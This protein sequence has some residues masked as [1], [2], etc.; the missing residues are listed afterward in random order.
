MCVGVLALFCAVSV[1]ESDLVLA[2]KDSTSAS[3]VVIPAKAE[4]VQEWAAEE[5]V[6]YVERV[7]GARLE[8]QRDDKPLPERAVLIGE[9]RYSKELLG[10]GFDFASLGDE[11]FRVA[12]QGRHLLIA[13]NSP[14]GVLYG[15]Y[16]VLERFGDVGFFAPWRIVSREKGSFA[17]PKGTDY[18]EKP[19]FRMREPTWYVFRDPDFASMLRVNGDYVPFEGRNGGRAHWFGGGLWNC[20]TFH[21][22][23]PPEKYFAEHPEYFSLVK[24]KRD[25]CAELCLTH[26]DVLRIA[27]SNVLARIRRDPGA[28]YYGVSQ[29]D[30]Q[31]PCTCENCLKVRAEEGDAD[32]GALVRFVN[33]IAEKVE[34]E[35]PDKI[36]QT[37][38]YQYNRKPPLK[39]R[40]RHNTTVCL[41]TIEC[42][43]FKPIPESDWKWDMRLRDDIRGWSAMTERLAIWDYTVNFTHYPMP[44]PNLNALQGNIRF[45]RENKV[46]EIYEQGAYQGRGGDMAELRAYM[47]AKWLWNPDLDQEALIG[48]FLEGYYG[49]AAPF[50]RQYLKELH[51]LPYDPKTRPLG[52]FDEPNLQKTITRAFIDRARGLWR[53]AEAAVSEDAGLLDNVKMS[54]FG[55]VYMQY[56][57][58]E[59]SETERKLELARWLLARVKEHPEIRLSEHRHNHERKL[60]EYRNCVEA[61]E[62]PLADLSA[63]DPR[64]VVVAAGTKTAYQGHPTMVQLDYGRL[65]AVWTDG[66]GGTCG[67]AAESADGGKTWMRIDERFPAGW[68]N[69]VNC[70]SIYELQGPDGKKRLWIWAQAKLP[71][72]AD[73]CDHGIRFRYPE[74]AMPSVMSED[75][76]KTWREMP[77]L[78]PKFKCVMAFSSIIR[79]KDG[80]YLGAFH[81]GPDGKD[82]HPLGVWTSVTKDGGFTWSEPKRALFERHNSFCEPSLIRSPDGKTLAMLCR[83]NHR[84]LGR[85]VIAFSTDEGRHWSDYRPTSWGLTGDRHVAVH[86][87][88]GRYFIAMRD[89]AVGSKTWG[90]YVAWV[91]TWGDLA[92]SGSGAIRLR[93]L[94]HR[95][96]DKNGSASWDTGYSGVVQ[97]EDGTVV[98]VTYMK[99]CDD[100]CRQSVVAKRISVPMYPLEFP[101]SPHIVAKISDCDCY[102]ALNPHFKNAFAFL[103]RKDLSELNVGRHEI[104][105]DNCWAMVQEVKL[106]ALEGGKMEAH[107]KY[108]DI[109]TPISG[110]E[111]VGF[112]TMDAAHRALPFDDEKDFVLFDGKAESRTLQ[113]GEFAIFFPP[114]GAHAPGH[115]L[116]PQSTIRKLVIKVRAE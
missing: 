113:P 70:P 7:S 89:M 114:D 65:I 41:C 29:M 36:I 88:D 67:P 94:N 82:E 64:Q 30:W 19:A 38:A 2:E 111:T 76:G 99:V 69:A 96:N 73:K 107:R 105:G 42:D 61:N 51:A 108:I 16:D 8:I 4:R 34:E 13:G 1:G 62:L 3:T 95:G 24:G 45:F 110:S 22:L 75:C 112:F 86:L 101:P 97:E 115:T 26:P 102:E 6:K 92:G 91:G 14:R 40:L 74:A 31:K 116:G 100:E 72:G 71:E 37:L 56:E 50:V 48:R 103:K 93:I 84:K 98:C 106:T 20:H 35:F 53:E 81:V 9:T 68:A 33:A 63:E 55:I 47:L 52:I 83:E 21:K 109:H 78:G 39:A 46:K 10:E 58:T 66:H 43:F 54:E 60:M 90:Q 85:S 27:T 104:D 15:V 44:F 32:S 79:L 23:L 12:A 80:S 77:P 87:K 57:L 5:F 25:P 18:I 11:G 59:K 49:A 17:V 28:K